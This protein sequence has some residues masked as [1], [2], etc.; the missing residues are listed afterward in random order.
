[1]IEELTTENYAEKNTEGINLISFSNDWCAQCFTQEPILKK[2][3]QKYQNKIHFYQ[4]NADK[5]VDIIQKYNV[6]SAPSLVIEKDG[7]AVYDVAGFLDE[8]QMDNII[9]YYA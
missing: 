6:L 7:E 1:M 2:M 3:A 5:N 9:T 8:T 4:I